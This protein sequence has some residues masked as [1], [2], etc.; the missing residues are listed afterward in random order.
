[1]TYGSLEENKFNQI[2][3]PI[4]AH[5]YPNEPLPTSRDIDEIIESINSKIGRF[6]QRIV[7]FQFGLNQ[8]QYY[9]FCS[10]AKTSI[11][12]MHH[13]FSETELDYFKMLFL[14]VI[15]SE[16]LNISPLNA[17]NIQTATKIN[18]TRIEKMIEN[19]IMDGEILL[20][21]F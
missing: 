4:F 12:S 19:W 5:F 6:D 14:I 10:T 16:D 1:M 8:A 7:K 13:T 9:M 11:S 15:E 2:F 3:A 18:K 21:I 17:L 20:N